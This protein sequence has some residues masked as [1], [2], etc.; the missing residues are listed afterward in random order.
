MKNLL[1]LKKVWLLSNINRTTLTQL[2]GMKRFL[3]DGITSGEITYDMTIPDLLNKIDELMH[4][5]LKGYNGR[6][7]NMKDNDTEDSNFT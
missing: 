2:S 7:K 5:S 1:V 3:S 6:L 4:E